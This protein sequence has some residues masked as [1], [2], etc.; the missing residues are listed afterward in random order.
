[1]FC[2]PYLKNM[3]TVITSFCRGKAVYCNGAVAYN[4]NRSENDLKTL[5]I[6]MPLR[7]KIC[8]SCETFA[9]CNY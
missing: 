9:D 5:L 3:K 1:M 7:Y 4:Y 8:Y 6:S 2:M